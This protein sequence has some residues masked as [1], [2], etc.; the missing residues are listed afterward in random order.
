MF[1]ASFATSFATSFHRAFQNL[2][3]CFLFLESKMEGEKCKYMYFKIGT[4]KLN[5]KS[6]ADSMNSKKN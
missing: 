5:L 4:S 2:I 6:V 3:F 1:I